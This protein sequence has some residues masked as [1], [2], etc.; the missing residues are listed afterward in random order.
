MRLFQHRKP[1]VRHAMCHKFISQTDKER[2]TD[3]ACNLSYVKDWL[4]F[5]LSP[6]LPTVLRPRVKVTMT[7]T[8]KW[9]EFPPVERGSDFPPKEAYVVW[10]GVSS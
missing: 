1:A 7:L 2:E 6:D 8:R 10:V 4:T 3:R 5:H 9:T